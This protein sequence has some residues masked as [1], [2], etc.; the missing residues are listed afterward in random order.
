[1]LAIQGIWGWG[2]T[3]TVALVGFVLVVLILVLMVFIMKL[4]GYVFTVQKKQQP[5]EKVAPEDEKIAAIALALNLYKGNLHDAESEV[6]TIHKIK[7]VYSPWNSKI[8]G[9]TQLPDFKRK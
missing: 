6:I 2:D 7:S 8:H 4:F 9:L 3:L 5:V 1:M